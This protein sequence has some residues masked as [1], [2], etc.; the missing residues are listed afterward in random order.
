MRLSVETVAGFVWAG[1]RGSKQ[2]LYSVAEVLA[3]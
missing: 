1:K 2:R 3:E